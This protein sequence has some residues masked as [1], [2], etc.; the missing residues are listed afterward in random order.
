MKMLKTTTCNYNFDDNFEKENVIR[1]LM[2]MLKQI[3]CNQNCDTK[4]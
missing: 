4:K 2:N 1:S 3:K